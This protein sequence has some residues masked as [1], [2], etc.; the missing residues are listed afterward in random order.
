M[1]RREGFLSRE[2]PASGFSRRH[3]EQHDWL[4]SHASKKNALLSRDPILP[5]VVEMGDSG[6]AKTG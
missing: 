2:A 1:E 3:A 4:V 5:S 6:N